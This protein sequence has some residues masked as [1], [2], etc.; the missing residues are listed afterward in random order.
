MVEMNGQ[1]QASVDE[2]IRRRVQEPTLQLTDA[3]ITSAQAKS[4]LVQR[5]LEAACIEA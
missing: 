3:G 5:L 1:R 4:R 2:Q